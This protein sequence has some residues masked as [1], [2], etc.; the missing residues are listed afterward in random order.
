[1]LPT[2]EL[3]SISTFKWSARGAIPEPGKKYAGLTIYALGAKQH[4][5]KWMKWWLDRGMKRISPG[6]CYLAEIAECDHRSNIEGVITESDWKAAGDWN[7]NQPHRPLCLKLFGCD[8]LKMQSEFG[9]V[10]GGFA[11]DGRDFLANSGAFNTREFTRYT[12]DS[13]RGKSMAEDEA[14]IIAGCFRANQ[15]K[16]SKPGGREW[17]LRP[18]SH[19]TRAEAL[20]ASRGMVY[21]SR[22]SKAD[23]SHET[24]FIRKVL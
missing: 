15:Q 19:V 13:R 22:P 5:D 3:H 20:A 21:E 23:P 11:I 17:R 12:S 7:R 16:L 6:F 8:F 24:K 4:H 14:K 1:M 9:V 10:M 2:H 18:E